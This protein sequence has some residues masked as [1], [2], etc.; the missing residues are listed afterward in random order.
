[1]S[2]KVYGNTSVY[3]FVNCYCS[4]YDMGLYFFVCIGTSGDRNTF[5]GWGV[6]VG[7]M[8]MMSTGKAEISK[9]NATMDQTVKAVGE[10]K[11]ELC[12]RKASCISKSPCHGDMNTYERCEYPSSILTE[13]PEP[14]HAVQK[15]DQLEADLEYELS[16]LTSCATELSFDK[17]SQLYQT[18]VLENGSKQMCN[19]YQFEGVEPSVLDKKLS[20]LLIQQQESQINELEHELQSTNSKLHQ[21]EA[22]LRALKDCVRRLSNFSLSNISENETETTA[23]EMVAE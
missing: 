3:A 11:S 1:M 10:L 13:E 15:M 4:L 16:K 12:K 8:Y 18:E 2:T 17:G 23:D 19:F 7:I 9:L 21:K 5:F 22:E 14:Q 20:Q 6:G